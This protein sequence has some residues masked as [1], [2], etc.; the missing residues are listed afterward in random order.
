[1]KGQKWQ[2]LK[3][4]WV[5]LMVHRGDTHV[6][7]QNH[8]YTDAQS[9]SQRRDMCV[10]YSAK[11]LISDFPSIRIQGNISGFSPSL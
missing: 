9:V 7:L 2:Q 11:S 8:R 3:T 10:A 5:L 6:K 4:D 1:M